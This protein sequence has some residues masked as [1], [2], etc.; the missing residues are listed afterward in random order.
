MPIINKRE[1]GE[2]RR[3]DAARGKTLHR[4]V[5]T[6]GLVLVAAAAFGQSLQPG[7]ITDTRTGCKVW[8]PN[9]YPNE[10]I[11][12]SGSCQ[13]GI[14]NGRGTL[15]W[16]KDGKPESTNAGEYRD[17]QMTGYG[18]RTWPNGARL[19]GNF[20]DD[21]LVGHGVL[22]DANGRYEGGFVNGK[23]SGRGVMIWTNGSRYEGEW[24]N[25][26]PNGLGMAVITGKT[27]NG[28]WKNG[29]YYTD[30]GLEATW[31]VD[32]SACQ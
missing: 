24:Q 26:L 7:W 3:M 11:S 4:S 12:W 23:Q 18:V 17:G 13:N 20:V 30:R 2:K 5:L 25:N 27:H 6:A 16:F 15:S 28:V 29:C 19:E 21:E 9:P 8:N 22:T 14:A 10:S 32:K 31:G 1:L